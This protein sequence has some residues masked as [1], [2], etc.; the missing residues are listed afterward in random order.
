[1]LMRI[2][3]PQTRKFLPFFSLF[4]LVVSFLILLACQMYGRRALIFS[5][6]SVVILFVSMAEFFRKEWLFRKI[7]KNKDKKFLRFGG[8]LIIF[9]LV[10]G[11]ARVASGVHRPTDIIAGSL[12]GS[13]VPLILMRKPIYRFGTGIAERIGK[14]I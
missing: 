11:F 1:M 12:V 9:S 8:I 13:I 5:V 6:F 7:I 10:T 3:L 4:F 2:Y 14:I